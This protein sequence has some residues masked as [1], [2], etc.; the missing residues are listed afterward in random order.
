MNRLAAVLLACAPE[1]TATPTPYP[2]L[3][4]TPTWKFY[5]D[6]SPVVDEN[7][8]GDVWKNMTEKRTAD[9]AEDAQRYIYISERWI[10]YGMADIAERLTDSVGDALRSTE[11]TGEYSAANRFADALVEACLL[12]SEA[13]IGT[14]EERELLFAFWDYFDAAGLLMIMAEVGT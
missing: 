10:T 4:P 1:P 13:G 5:E 9:S 14:D 3:T 12:A 6:Y 11:E 8:F 2:T 7:G